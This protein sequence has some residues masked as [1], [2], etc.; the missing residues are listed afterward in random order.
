[1]AIT[2]DTPAN[3]WRD[4]ADQLTPAQVSKLVGMELNGSSTAMMLTFARDMAEGNVTDA[5][6]FGHLP[7]PADATQVVRSHQDRDTGVWIR[8]FVGSEWNIADVSL[9]VDGEQR[10]DG[11][12]SRSLI[13]SVSD[14]GETGGGE[15]T[16]DHARELAAALIEAANEL[17]RL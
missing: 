4:V 15:L 11:Q 10:A 7:V 17:D 1:M 14:V 13:V 8:P 12:V 2:P 6:H 3:G 9:W 16:I 5:F